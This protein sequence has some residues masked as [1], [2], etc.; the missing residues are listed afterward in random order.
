MYHYL[1]VNHFLKETKIN[2]IIKIHEDYYLIKNDYQ[3]NIFLTIIAY[4][5][6]AMV[7]H[8]KVIHHP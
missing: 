4:H 7:V 3:Q 8:Q 1:C 6:L 2:V 5:F